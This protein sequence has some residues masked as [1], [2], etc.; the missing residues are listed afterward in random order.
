MLEAPESPQEGNLSACVRKIL[1]TEGVPPFAQH[2]NELM[3]RSV[4]PNGG[5]AHLARIILKDLGLTLHVLRIANSP[6]Y[7]RS[8]RAIIGVVHAITLLGWE[9]VR[10][11]VGAMHFIE[12]YARQSPGLR[13]LMMF[14]LLTATHSREIA[15]QIGYPRPEE[16]YVCGLFRNLGEVLLARHSPREYA[17]M[18]LLVKNE[19][20]TKNAACRRVF[21]FSFEELAMA[22]TDCWAMPP[23]VRQTLAGVET[24]RTAEERCLASVINYG[25]DLTS[26]L[27]RQGGPVESLP[28]R[29]IF[30]PTGANVCLTKRDLRSLVNQAVEDTEQTFAAL[31]I[32]MGSLG[33]DRQAEQALAILTS[34]DQPSIPADYADI[35]EVIGAAE[36]SLASPGFEISSFIQNLLDGIIRHCGFRRVLF[37]LLSEDR[38]AIRG[39]IG[40]GQEVAQALHLFQFSL[41]R[42]DPALSAAIDRRLDLWIN[43]KADLRY[44]ASRVSALFESPHWL[45]LPVVVDNIVAGVMFGEC[46]SPLA[47][48]EVRKRVEEVRMLIAAGIGKMRLE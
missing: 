23:M 1:S 8:G 6:L 27:Y 5:S 17:Q 25:H 29:A 18:L 41:M 47:E 44:T 26:V 31:R 45:L 12:H 15:A 30:G 7:N 4:D 38:T 3:K 32:P 22:L 39:R 9:T 20:M 34:L 2:A 37:A 21:G 19:G 42:S 14:S 10:S 13:E 36:R 11:V 46:K 24:C 43:T 28:A 48:P 40:S 35:D 33:L 16:A